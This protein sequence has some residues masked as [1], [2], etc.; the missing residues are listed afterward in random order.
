MLNSRA[1]IQVILLNAAL[2]NRPLTATEIDTIK[3][4]W[5]LAELH[6]VEEVSENEAAEQ[7]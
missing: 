3:R 7:R 1:E 4:N 2:E 6:E 5:T